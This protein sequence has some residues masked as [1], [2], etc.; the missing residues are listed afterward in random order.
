MMMTKLDRLWQNIKNELLIY[1]YLKISDVSDLRLT[2]TSKNDR[3]IYL[4]PS[5][6]CWRPKLGGFGA[7]PAE[8]PRAGPCNQP[9]DQ[10]KNV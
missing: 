5:S 1:K 2:L 4:L 9:L 6:K 8:G 10:L 3:A 7:R